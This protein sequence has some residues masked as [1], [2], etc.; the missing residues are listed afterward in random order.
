VQWQREQSRYQVRLD[1]SMA[2]LVPLSIISQ[3]E[4]TNTGPLPRA[5]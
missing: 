3:G 1:L 4:A 5:Y 2:L